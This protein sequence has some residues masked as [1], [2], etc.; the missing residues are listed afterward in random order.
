MTSVTDAP[1]NPLPFERPRSRRAAGN[2]VIRWLRANLFP[3]IP[4][5]IISLLLI[6]LLAKAVRASCSGASECDLECS[7]Q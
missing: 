6:L 3:S 4:S 5:T 7:G 2:R 1:E